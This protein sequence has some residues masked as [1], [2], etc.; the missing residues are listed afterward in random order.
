MYRLVIVMLI[1][2][3]YTLV[4][5]NCVNMLFLFFVLNNH[6]CIIFPKFWFW[7]FVLLCLCEQGITVDCTWSI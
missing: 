1:V 7:D 2:I 5:C 3:V 6:L 4:N